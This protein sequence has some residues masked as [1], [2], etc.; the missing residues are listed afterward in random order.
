M[1]IPEVGSLVCARTMVVLITLAIAGTVRAQQ[2]KIGE[3]Y[4]CTD[5]HTSIKITQCSSGNPNLCD[6]EAFND[7]NPA[8]GMRL[9]APVVNDLLRMCL[10][11]TPAAPN[12]QSNS[13]SPQ[14]GVA[15][16]NG[17]KIGDTVSINTAFGWMDAKILKANGNS[18]LV[19]AQSGAEVWKPYPAELRRIGPVNDTDRARGLFALHDRVK[20]KVDGRWEEGE[21]IMEMN[22][23]Y[24]IALAGNRTAWAAPGIMQLISPQQKPAAPVAGKPPQSGMVSCAG[25]IEG[26][27]SSSQVGAFTIVFRKGKAQLKMYGDAEEEVECWMSGTKI[28]LHKPGAPNE[29]MPIEINDD[30]TLDT[31]MGEVRKKSS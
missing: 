3:L 7:G 6:I 9:A 31:P 5:G 4:K 24:Q 30:G 12:A 28:I 19:H 1:L 22:H 10:G 29:D 23:E 2:P 20:V 15:D 17:F 14:P 26:R 27:Y 25:K 16:A 11:A 8:P 21:V 13:P 18:Y